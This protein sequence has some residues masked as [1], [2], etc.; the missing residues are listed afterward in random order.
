MS[1]LNPDGALQA[2]VFFARGKRVYR[3]ADAPAGSSPEEVRGSGGLGRAFATIDVLGCLLP[4]AHCQ[5]L[6]NGVT[7]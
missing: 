4:A 6:P 2:D 5:Q 7:T 1:W 3:I